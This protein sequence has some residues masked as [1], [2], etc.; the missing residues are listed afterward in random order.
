MF[1]YCLR[2]YWQKDGKRFSTSAPG[3]ESDTG[4]TF[5]FME[6]SRNHSGIYQCFAY[7]K[8]GTAM[9]QKVKVDVAGLLSRNFVL[10]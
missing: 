6:A 10:F 8:F 4:G 9:S 1:I 2:Y 5:K 7:N 3:I